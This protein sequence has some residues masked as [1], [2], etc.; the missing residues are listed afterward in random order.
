[1]KAVFLV[2]S[3]GVHNLLTERTDERS[4][5]AVSNKQ[6]LSVFIDILLKPFSMIFRVCNLSID[7]ICLS[8]H[9]S[10]T[11]FTVALR[12]VRG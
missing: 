12:T 2:G 6:V 8:V 3:V 9:L 1:V 10:V 4:L 5:K 7:L 11:M